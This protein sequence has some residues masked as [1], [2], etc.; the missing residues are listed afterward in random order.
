[1][2]RRTM[3]LLHSEYKRTLGGLRR[4]RMSA[5]LTN[6]TDLSDQSFFVELVISE[7]AHGI[8]QKDTV[9]EDDTSNEITFLFI[10]VH[11]YHRRF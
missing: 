7:I 1:M 8:V 6:C 9:H 2:K 3:I 5:S 10:T 11:E 4:A